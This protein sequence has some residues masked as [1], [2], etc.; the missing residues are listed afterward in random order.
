M[1]CAIR[2]RE[3]ERDRDAHI[4]E[5]EF[6]LQIQISKINAQSLPKKINK[7]LSFVLS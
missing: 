3:R 6:E 1:M 2:G 7:C 4:Y 5:S